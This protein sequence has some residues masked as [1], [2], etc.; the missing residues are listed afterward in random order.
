M[1]DREFTHAE[2]GLSQADGDSASHAGEVVMPRVT[3]K[4]IDE[5]PLF[6]RLDFQHDSRPL[7][8]TNVLSFVSRM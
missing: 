5:K 2:R 6:V 3:K 1:S 8:G 4:A 7:V